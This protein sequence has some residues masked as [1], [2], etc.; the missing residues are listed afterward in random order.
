MAPNSACL[1]LVS[2]VDVS[3]HFV[4][5]ESFLSRRLGGATTR[6]TLAVDGV[7]LDIFAGQTVGLV[8]E[9]GCGKSTFGRTL[10]GLT[11]PTSGQVLYEGSP[12]WGPNRLGR[13][14][15]KHR[16][17]I[18]FQNPY[19]SLNPR[20]TVRRTIAAA[21]AARGARPGDREQEA[22]SLV[23]RVGLTPG[24]LD[25]YP[26]QLSGGQRQRVGIARA[27]AMRP[28]FI[29]ADE[30]LSS[31]DV[32]VQ[33]QIITLLQDLQ[34]EY[35]LSYLLI[36]HDLRVVY[37]MSDAVAVMY[38]GQI[39][40]WASADDLFLQPSHP[41]TQQLLSAIPGSGHRL[42]RRHSR[43]T[44]V[45]DVERG[46]RR[47]EADTAEV[48]TPLGCRFAHRCPVATRKCASEPPILAPLSKYSESSPH[49]VRCHNSVPAPANTEGG[50]TSR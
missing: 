31:L 39:V 3:K 14:D 9:S 47:P 18:I 23:T 11:E 8:G 50:Y 42:T 44:H 45:P 5:A 27:L 6:R 36:S 46:S 33:A 20:Y 12:V 7:N 37:Y 21:L 28:R 49:L 29:V 22:R 24:H 32:S 10:V 48:P 30:P 41:Y 19:S 26:H 38:R 34:R 40:E 4:S 16:A 13:G 1:P 2:A 15:L 25:R 43:Q 35:G 17:Q